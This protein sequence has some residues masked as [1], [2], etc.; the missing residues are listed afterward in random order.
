MMYSTGNTSSSLYSGLD[1]HLRFLGGTLVATYNFLPACLFISAFRISSL[2]PSPYAQ[3]VS[4]KLQPIST[5]RSS[6]LFT[7][8]ASEPVQPAIPHMPYPTSLT[9]QPVRPNVLYCILI[10]GLSG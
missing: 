6:A 3:A 5:A 4:K 9:F 10:I 8:S 2:S 7:S 1:G